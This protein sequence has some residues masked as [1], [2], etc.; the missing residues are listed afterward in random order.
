RDGTAELSELTSS[1]LT[2]TNVGVFDVDSGVPILNPGE[3]VIVAIGAI[4]R[5]PWEHQGQVALRQVVSITVS[6]DHRVLDGAQ[7]SAFLSGITAVLS[8]PAIAL[9]G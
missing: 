4:R 5:R 7:A 6:F 9:M 8:D 1:T 2:V 3:S